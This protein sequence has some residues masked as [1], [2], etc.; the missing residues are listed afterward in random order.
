MSRLL[1]LKT[2]PR[3]RSH[4]VAVADAFVA[5]W[6]AANPAAEVTTRDLF[7]VDLPPFDGP[8]LQGKY[9]IMHGL[10]YSPE[11][12]EAWGR[13]T[14]II[15]DFASFDRYVLAVPM[16]NFNIPYR[17]KHFIDIVCQPTLTFMPRPDGTYAGL[18][19]GRKVYISYARGGVY[20]PG[21][22]AEAFNFQAPYLEFILGFMG[23]TDI[24]STAVEGTLM[25]KETAD[26]A[27]AE[28]L[29]KARTL[30][31]TF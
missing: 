6:Q 2:S 19:T 1:Y 22:P 7:R 10:P 4:S 15:A 18:L 11:E 27:Q 26:A 20:H 3:G 14:E 5:A 16:W 8:A 23:L 31:A 25:G 24:R 30:A 12:R 21:T 28:A 17:L 29:A 13:V 9:N